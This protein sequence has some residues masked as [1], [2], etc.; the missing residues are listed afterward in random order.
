MKDFI[1]KGG[2]V[3]LEETSISKSLYVF[4]LYH[5]FDPCADF[6]PFQFL[7]FKLGGN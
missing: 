6:S 2:E 7:D 1:I 4:C 5:L 3:M